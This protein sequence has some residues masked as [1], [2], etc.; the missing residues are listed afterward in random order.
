MT[1]LIF[2]HIR[3]TGSA[4]TG[5]ST[6]VDSHTKQHVEGMGAC[7]K[8]GGVAVPR[9]EAWEA[10]RQRGAHGLTK[11]NYCLHLWKECKGPSAVR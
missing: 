11:E 8:G 1:L 4:V 7:P 10:G 3:P 5:D 2:C 6:T 9:G